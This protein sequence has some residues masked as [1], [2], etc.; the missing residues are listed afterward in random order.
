MT[1]AEK[2]TQL[3]LTSPEP[4]QLTP[5]DLL[6]QVL[7][8][9][10]PKDAVEVVKELV[11]LQTD[12]RKQDAEVEFN[13]A[14]SA[15]SAEMKLVINDSE[16][17][18]PWGKRWATY[19]AL[20]KAAK[21][22][23][24]KYG[25]GVSYDAEPLPNEQ[26]LVIA[27]VSKGLHTRRYTVPMDISGK[28]PQGGG[29]LTKPNAVGAGLEYARRDLIR[30]I[31]DLITGE[32]ELLTSTVDADWLTEHIAEI[33]RCE[34]LEGLQ[35]AYTAAANVALNDI[36]DIAAYHQIKAAKEKRKKELGGK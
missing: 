10:N 20:N 24:T 33:G 2:D 9:Q 22:I 29:A 27:Y 15:A 30:M 13:A 26:M 8:T 28:G 5:M 21:P 11:K 32:E 34:T 14:L 16:K 17:A 35:D 1:V 18:G 7:Q 4:K 12:M 23:W 36:K 31:F 3:V 25:L 6:Q 19:R